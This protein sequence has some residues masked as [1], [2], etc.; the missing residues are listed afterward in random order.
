M[1]SPQIL[2]CHCAYAKVAPVEVKQHVLARL[3]ESG[4][5][6]DAVADLCEMAAKGDPALQQLACQGDLRI[7]ACYPRAVKW[8]FA[9][10]GT[11]L[12]AEAQVLNMREQSGEEIVAKLFDAAEPTTG[13][14]SAGESSEASTLQGGEA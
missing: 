4:R 3:A 9:S 6:F 2:Y 1:S 11:P 7:V 8:L 5:A 12:H 14:E 13:E 10:A